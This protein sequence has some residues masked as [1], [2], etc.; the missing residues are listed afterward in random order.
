MDG[1]ENEFSDYVGRSMIMEDIVTVSS[2]HKLTVTLNRSDPIPKIGD[3]VPPGWHHVLFPRFPL[4]KDLGGDGMV[5]EIDDGPVD[6]LPLRMFAG[7]RTRFHQL[8][9]IGDA[10]TQERKLVSMVPKEGKSG[11]LVFG[12]YAHTITGPNGL[13]TEDDWD[14]VF[15]EE[16]KDGTRKP[17]PPK[18]GPGSAD[19]DRL[20]NVNETM[21]FRYSACTFNPHRIHYDHP[22]TTEVEGYPGLVVHGPLTATW[23]LELARDNMPD[24]TMTGFQMRAIAPIYANQD[25]RLVGNVTKEGA[26]CDLW[27]L[28]PEGNVAMEAAVTFRE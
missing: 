24:K 21:L 9:R 13:C 1:G 22:Y 27:V 16:D 25:I 28:T 12:T 15:M 19:W 18:P 20:I 3:P 10:V 2:V 23:L 26:A 8:I 17:P 14:L 4:T 11:K 6:P 5:S 7:S